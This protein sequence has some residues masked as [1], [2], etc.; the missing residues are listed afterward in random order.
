MSVLA[1]GK[2]VIIVM[3]AYKAEKTVERTHRAIPIEWVDEVILGDDGSPDQTAVIARKLGIKTLAHEKNEG[4]GENQ[5]TCYREA[6][7]DGGDIIV[8]LHADFQYDP[9]YIPKMVKL[10]SEENADVVFGS[11]MSTKRGALEGGMPLWKFIANRM[12]TYIEDFIY[13]LDLS[14][15]HTG[16]RAYNRKVLLTIPFERNA[17]DFAFDAEIF[18]QL[19]IAG[20]RVA[21]VPILTRYFKEASSPNLRAS[22]VYG[23]QTLLVAAKYILHRLHLKTFPIFIMN[24]SRNPTE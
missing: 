22:T 18:P 14:E 6:L 4:Y 19:K 8:M 11:R 5:K 20:F 1:N 17:S 23:L 10:I 15:Y 24:E 16:Y 9:A 12:L 3:I 2:K 21:E 13:G 7:K